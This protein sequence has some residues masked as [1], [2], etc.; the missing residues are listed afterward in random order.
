[1]DG[2]C[3]SNIVSVPLE[4]ITVPDVF[5]A[6]DELC[7]AGNGMATFDL[8]NLENT[9]TGGS[10]ATINWVDGSFP[11]GNG[12][13]PPYTTGSTTIFAV[14]NNGNC[15]NVAPV[16]LTVQ[17]EVPAFPTMDTQCDDGSGTAIFNLDNLATIVNGGNTNIVDWFSDANATMPI[18]SS[19]NSIATSVYAVVDDGNCTSE[20]VEVVLNISNILIANPTSDT[21]C[22]LSLIHISEP[23]RPY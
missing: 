5:P 16:T 15:F 4:V 17:D 23:T 9:I 1:M 22:D 21:Q 3:T 13:T 14:V 6:S 19:Y 2:N 7:D 12:I 18:P 10:G 20:P 8:T 11:T